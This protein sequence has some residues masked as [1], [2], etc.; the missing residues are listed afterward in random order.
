M[1]GGRI[2]DGMRGPPWY[3]GHVGVQACAAVRAGPLRRRTASRPDPAR[4]T[5]VAP[6][7][8]GDLARLIRPFIGPDPIGSFPATRADARIRDMQVL[9]STHAEAGRPSRRNVVTALGLGLA[10]VGAAA[11]LVY[12]VFIGNFLDRFMPVGRPSTY[13]LV[14]GALA[15]T[16]ALTAPA[17]FGLIGLARLVSAYEKWRARRPRI[18]PAVRLRRTIGDDHVVATAVRVPDGRPIPELVVGPFGAAVIEELPP[19]AAVVSRGP[20]TWEVRLGNGYIRTIDN[21]LERAAHDAERVR[22][23]LSPDD[24]DYVLKVYAVVV[25]KD[26]AKL[27]RTPTCA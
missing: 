15:W 7:G 8:F 10:L 1:N 13:E 18:T 21:P 22:G 4:S 2:R 14:A 27:E 24:A 6:A 19:A 20:R 3:G 17:G 11:A 5:P 16:F 26:A 25:G 9:M 12:L 23:W